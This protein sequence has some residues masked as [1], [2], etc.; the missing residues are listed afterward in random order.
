MPAKKMVSL[1]DCEKVSKVQ[2]YNAVNS[3]RQKSKGKRKIPNEYALFV[4]QHM[5]DPKVKRLPLKKRMGAI[6]L[7]W[8]DAKKQQHVFFMDM[9]D[10][11]DKEEKKEEKKEKKK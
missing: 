5:Q 10:F 11:D 8:K 1:K 4:R 7:L 2:A 3:Y 9:S 6:A